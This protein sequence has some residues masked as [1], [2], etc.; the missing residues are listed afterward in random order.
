MEATEAR[1]TDAENVKALSTSWKLSRG[2][3]EPWKTT[4]LLV[5]PLIYSVI[6]TPY[7]KMNHMTR[8]ATGSLDI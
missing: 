1:D 8:Q 2:V 5:S 3:T 7:M 4:N 6:D